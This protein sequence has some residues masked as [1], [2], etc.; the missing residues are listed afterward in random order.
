[1]PLWGHQRKW[2]WPR[3]WHRRVA[4]LY[5]REKRISPRDVVAVSAGAGSTRCSL[6]RDLELLTS[7]EAASIGQAQRRSCA[8]RAEV[9]AGS[10]LSNLTRM[11]DKAAEKPW[12]STAICMGGGPAWGGTSCTMPRRSRRLATC[13]SKVHLAA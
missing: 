7:E 6:I 9:A 8:A 11:S 2:L 13:A 12:K 4:A 3:G 1:R 5:G 10:I